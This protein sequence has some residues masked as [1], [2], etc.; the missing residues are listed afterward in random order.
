MTSPQ[1]SA[2]QKQM[3]ASCY[4]AR[5]KK[6]FQLVKK[7][8]DLVEGHSEFDGHRPDLEEQA[9]LLSSKLQELDLCIMSH[10]ADTADNQ[11]Q[12]RAQSRR[13]RHS[14]DQA[15][16]KNLR[17]QAEATRESGDELDSD[18]SSKVKEKPKD[19]GRSVSLKT[20]VQRFAYK[21][22]SK[23]NWHW[24]KKSSVQT[25]NK[26]GAKPSFLTC[27][28]SLSDLTPDVI[29]MTHNSQLNRMIITRDGSGIAEPPH[30]FKTLPGHHKIDSHKTAQD[31]IF[32]RLSLSPSLARSDNFHRQMKTSISSPTL[33]KIMKQHSESLPKDDNPAS[34]NA[35]ANEDFNKSIGF[36]APNSTKNQS[37]FRLATPRRQVNPNALAEIEVSD[38]SQ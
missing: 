23:A 27:S 28:N 3:D 15:S 29:D 8:P 13:L 22:F 9:K 12:S 11:S 24:N 35:P 38:I 25:D 30:G 4:S 21:T 5:E 18:S 6:M 2:I 19:V 16:L 17:L 26:E 36:T 34:H 1:L 31:E 32:S 10:A 37:S 7:K 33:N 20:S 14:Y